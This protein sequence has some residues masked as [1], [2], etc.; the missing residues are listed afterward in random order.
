MAVRNRGNLAQ[1][2]AGQ[3]G[4]KRGTAALTAM[5]QRTC[6]SATSR[7]CCARLA[8]ALN[9]VELGHGDSF[10]FIDLP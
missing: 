4:C 5:L 2:S 9:A 8:P 10:A 6:P 3:H 7:G 1:K